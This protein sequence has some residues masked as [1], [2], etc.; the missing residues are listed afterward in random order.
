[1][2]DHWNP[3]RLLIDFQFRWTEKATTAAAVAPMITCVAGDNRKL[4]FVG[5]GG[6]D[7]MD[8]MAGSSCWVG[9]NGVSCCWFCCWQMM[10]DCAAAAIVDTGWS[11]PSSSW[12]ETV[13]ELDDICTSE[14]V[15][16][17]SLRASGSIRSSDS[18][19]SS[20]RRKSAIGS[21]KLADDTDN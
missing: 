10:R 8:G 15:W 9:S 18:S 2:S 11:T 19:R 17:G 5:S 7:W 16:R 21:V 13:C 14:A 1:M 3:K 12:I 6:D 20:A 4:S